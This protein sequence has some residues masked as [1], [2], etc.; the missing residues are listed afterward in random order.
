[1]KT[2][3]LNTRNTSTGGERPAHR[4]LAA[5]GLVVALAGSAMLS[6]TAGA[7]DGVI[8]DFAPDGATLGVATND[9]HDWGQCRARDFDGGTWDWYMRI[10]TDVA[11]PGFIVRHGMLAGYTA[12]G[13]PDGV[14]CAV[15]EEYPWK[16]GARQ[17]FTNGYLYWQNGLA[18]AVAAVNGGPAQWAIDRLGDVAGDTP[19]G[20]WSGWCLRF[21]YLAHGRPWSTRESAI[22]EWRASEAAGVAHFD[23]DPAAIPDGAIVYYSVGTFGHAGIHLGDGWVASTDGNE[24]ESRPIR[25]HRFDG[26]YSYLGWSWPL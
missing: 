19:T 20:T 8:A 22:E 23:T 17:D 4:R 2:R 13:G 5:V 12:T 1:M 3:I 18:R 7:D 14:G 21:A 11:A 15:N 25:I 16:A 26:V 6:S 24:G 10:A 9:W